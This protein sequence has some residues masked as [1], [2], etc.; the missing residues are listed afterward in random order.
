M[1]NQNTPNAIHGNLFHAKL[2]AHFLIRGVQQGY[3]FEL[4]TDKSLSVIF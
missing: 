1:K 2:L 3:K 4:G